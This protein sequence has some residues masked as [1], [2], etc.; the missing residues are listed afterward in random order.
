MEK[1]EEYTGE[2]IGLGTEGEGIIR[3]EG[4]TVF[5]PL[6][7]VGETVSFKVLKV[8]KDVAYG[9]VLQVTKPSPDRTI[10][11]C[12][13]F[14]QCG[15]C[16]LQHMKYPAQLKHKSAMVRTSLKKIGGIDAPVASTVPCDSAY[17]YRNKLALPIGLTPEGEPVCGFYAPR[18][19]RIIPIRDCYIQAEWVKD[20]IS[21]VLSYARLLPLEQRAKLRHIVVRKVG[22]RHIIALV[23]AGSVPS[24]ALTALLDRHFKDYTFLLNINPADTNV[25]FGPEWH[26]IRGEGLLRTEEGGISFT[27]GANTFM[28]VNDEVRSKLYACVLNEARGASAAIDLYS[29]GGLLTAMLAKACGEAWGIEIVPEATQC[30]NTLMAENDLAGRM[31]NICGAA[32][33]NVQ[34]L[35]KASEGGVIVCDPPRKGMERSVVKAIRESHA[36]KVVLISCNP[37]TLARDLGLLMGTLKEDGTNLVKSSSPESPYTLQSVTPFD[38]FPQTKWCETV[39]V[40]TRK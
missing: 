6:C 26:T 40:L 23:A 36:D 28:Q 7:L 4:K 37:A 25:I 30:A 10:P 34:I 38:M 12:P 39:C 31:H 29:G 11:V 13:A 2:V 5:V 32:E 8:Q 15:G 24:D 14:P 1:N 22:E 35:Q 17:R 18:S 27:V 9:K 19:H 16:S 3:C 33:D 20:I 21:C